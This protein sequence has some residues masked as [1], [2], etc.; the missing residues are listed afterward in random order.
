VINSNYIKDILDLLLDRDEDGL[1]A[2]QQVPFLMEN[3]F[4][5]TVAGVFVYFEHCTGIDKFRLE[6]PNL[7][8]NGVSITSEKYQIEAS[9][10]LFFKEGIIDYLEIWCHIGDYPKSDLTS[11]VLTQTWLNSKNKAIIKK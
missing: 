9:A 11:Y 8:L 1:L 4:N 6:T 2:R 7:V 10:N 3:D 5:Y